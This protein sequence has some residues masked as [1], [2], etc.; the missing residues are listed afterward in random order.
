MG[1]FAGKEV[2]AGSRR[3][4]FAS[5][6]IVEAAVA[7][8]ATLSLRRLVSIWSIKVLLLTQSFSKSASRGP[9]PKQSLSVLVLCS[10][11][12]SLLL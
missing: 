12:D 7:A 2:H 5:R 9:E 10:C 1:A 11:D 8:R 3:D 4:G 6:A